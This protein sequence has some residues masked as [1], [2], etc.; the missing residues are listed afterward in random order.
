MTQKEKFRKI[1]SKECP[2]CGGRLKL[3]DISDDKGDVSYTETFIECED[4][5][6]TEELNNKRNRGYQEVES[7][8]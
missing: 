4:C 2:E 6:Y 5:D 8:W 3:V 1:L 7:N